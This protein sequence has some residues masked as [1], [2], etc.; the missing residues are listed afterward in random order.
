MTFPLAGLLRVRRLQQDQ[1]AGDLA[2]ANRRHR[3]DVR[4][5]ERLAGVLA[6]SPVEVED[7][8]TLV[9]LVAA[10]ASARGLLAELR[11][12]EA[13]SASDV[14]DARAAHHD[15][16]AATT[17]LEKLEER[18][19]AGVT[20]EELRAEQGALDETAGQAWARSGK[21]PDR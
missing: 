2:R 16:R 13:G 1:R 21:G 20:L 14:E 7:R 10:R 15:A 17:S 11:A 9:A 5:T 19:A 8:A 6:G 3:E 12:S 18:H 4:R